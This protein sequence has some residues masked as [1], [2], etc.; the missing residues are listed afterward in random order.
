MAEDSSALA[1]HQSPEIK[2]CFLTERYLAGRLAL[3]SELFAAKPQA[4]RMRDGQKMK[5]FEHRVVGH[6]NLILDVFG[7]LAKERQWGFSSRPQFLNRENE[8]EPIRVLLKTKEF[9]ANFGLQQMPGCCAVLIAYYVD[10]KPWTQEAFYLALQAIE[11]AARAAGFGS[12]LMAQVVPANFSRHIGG[13]DREPW[14]K[15]LSRGWV[16]SEPFMNA[17]S[18]NWVIYLMKDLAQPGKREGLEVQL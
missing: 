13:W 18:G 9:K 2:S 15:C 7:E 4:G 17:K 14:F 16:D 3:R 10:V 12:V 11:E 6:P 1:D 8:W 5:T